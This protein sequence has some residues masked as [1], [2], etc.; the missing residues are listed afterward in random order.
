MASIEDLF[1]V[2]KSRFTDDNH[3]RAAADDASDVEIPKDLLFKCPRCGG[4]FYNEEFVNNLKVCPKCNYHARLTWQER[5]ELTAD[6]GSFK[7]LDET[8]GSLNP[9]GFPR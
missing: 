9:I 6:S 5:L 3:S 4:V 7:E 8:L 2:V 1:K